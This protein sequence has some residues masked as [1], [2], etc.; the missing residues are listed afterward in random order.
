MD[1]DPPILAFV[2]ASFDNHM[3]VAGNSTRG[4]YLVGD[5]G[6]HIP[7]GVIVEPV[8]AQALN[9]VDGEIRTVATFMAP[10]SPTSMIAQPLRQTSEESALSKAETVV[11]TVAFPMPERQAR[12]A[13]GC[14]DDHHTVTCDLLNLPG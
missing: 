7:D 1:D 8:M 10:G 9:D 3:L 11:T 6:R 4:V 2:L 12:G 14:G 5:D 13:A